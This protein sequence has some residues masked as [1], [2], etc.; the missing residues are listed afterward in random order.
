M[1]D[2]LKKGGDKVSSLISASLQ[3]RANVSQR[4]ESFS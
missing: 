1:M 4:K 3:V 2:A